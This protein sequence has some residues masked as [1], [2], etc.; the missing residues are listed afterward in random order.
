MPFNTNSSEILLAQF[1]GVL[2]KSAMN[3]EVLARV[4]DHKLVNAGSDTV[5]D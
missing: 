3:Q 4:G 5:I 2:L 1:K